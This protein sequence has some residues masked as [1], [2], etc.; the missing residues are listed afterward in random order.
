MATKKIRSVLNTERNEWIEAFEV[1]KEYEIANLPVCNPGSTVLVKETGSTYS[2]GNN[3]IWAIS[4][5]AG[6][7]VADMTASDSSVKATI[8]GVYGENAVNQ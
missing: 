7:S 3:G 5:G 4:S 8:D 1:D 2:V 6:G